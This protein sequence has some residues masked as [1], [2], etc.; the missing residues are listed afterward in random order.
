[1]ADGQ[2]PGPPDNGNLFDGL[3]QSGVSPERLLRLAKGLQKDDDERHKERHETYKWSIGITVTVFFAVTSI[4][5]ALVGVT[6]I[7]V[8]NLLGQY[9][10]LSAEIRD[11]RERLAIIE[12]VIGQ[13]RRP[14]TQIPPSS[15]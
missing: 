6:V 4:L 11:L 15:L 9:G 10:D 12:T 8:M 13:Q 5:I 7:I 1:M 3:Q 2:P 14:P